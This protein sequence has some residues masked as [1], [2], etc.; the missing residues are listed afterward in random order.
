MYEEHLYKQELLYT[1][2]N[3]NQLVDNVKMHLR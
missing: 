2:S 3:D 1:L